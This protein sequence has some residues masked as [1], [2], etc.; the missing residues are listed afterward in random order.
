MTTFRR[1]DLPPPVSATAARQ[2]MIRRAAMAGY[3]Q[4]QPLA[5]DLRQDAAPARPVSAE[6]ARQAVIARSS[7]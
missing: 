5:G 4:R 2:A 3:G 1:D 6:A 7:R